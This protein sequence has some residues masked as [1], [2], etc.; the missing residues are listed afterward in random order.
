[1]VDWFG[2]AAWGV[3]PGSMSPIRAH[4]NC[5]KSGS[6]GSTTKET[7]PIMYCRCME[8]LD[9]QPLRDYCMRRPRAPA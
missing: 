7:P 9:L 1:M 4:C 8:Y 6:K 5:L 3:G 2:P